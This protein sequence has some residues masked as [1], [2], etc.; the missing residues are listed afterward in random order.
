MFIQYPTAESRKRLNPPDLHRTRVGDLV[1]ETR[2][3][4]FW[5]MDNVYH[6]GYIVQHTMQHEHD[7]GVEYDDADV[8]Q[9]EELIADEL[10]LVHG[11]EDVWGEIVNPASD[12]I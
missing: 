10:V 5:P 2:V 12:V 7:I 4:I 1:N 9:V 8:D 6:G 3:A 11:E